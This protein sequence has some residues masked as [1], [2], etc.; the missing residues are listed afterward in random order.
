[1]GFSALT[2]KIPEL[3]IHQPD[4]VRKS[5]P[6]FFKELQN[7]GFRVKNVNATKSH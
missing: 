3:V 1:M 5:Y 4:A 2:F 7:V 6:T